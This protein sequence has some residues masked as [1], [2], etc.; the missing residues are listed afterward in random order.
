MLMSRY[1]PFLTI[2]I[3]ILFLLFSYQV[4]Q[5]L[6]NFVINSSSVVKYRWLVETSD[7]SRDPLIEYVGLRNQG[8][9][10]YMNSLLQQI[11]MI[12]EIRNAVLTAKRHQPNELI[13][14]KA[15]V[16]KKIAISFDH[17]NKPVSVSVVGYNTQ[18]GMHCIRYQSSMMYC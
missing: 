12:S 18:T 1:L 6:T 13:K 9:T 16:G 2:I 8:C 3:F 17:S 10:C 4:C 11:F 7:E 15:L 5:I 14:G